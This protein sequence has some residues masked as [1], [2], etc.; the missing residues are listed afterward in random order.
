VPRIFL[1][2]LLS[3]DAVGF[4][5]DRGEKLLV[6]ENLQPV[7]GQSSAAGHTVDTQ[8]NPPAG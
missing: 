8:Q 2:A 3:H 7:T 1:T 6:P 4:L 5:Y